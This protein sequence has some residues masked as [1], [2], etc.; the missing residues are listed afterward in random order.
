MLSQRIAL[1]V[2]VSSERQAEEHTIDSQ[3]A[4]LVARIAQDGRVLDPEGASSTRAT[5]APRWCAPRSSGCATWRLPARSIVFTS[6]RPTGSPAAT[7]TKSSCSMSSAAP[8]RGGVPQ[9][10]D[11]RLARGRPAIA[12]PGH[13]GRIRTGQAPQASRR[14]GVSVKFSPH[15]L[16]RYRCLPRMKPFLMCASLPHPLHRSPVAPSP[17][18][19]ISPRSEKIGYLCAVKPSSWKGSDRTA[20]AQL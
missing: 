19:V 17:S 8:A 15:A 7:P 14:G 12:G 16:Q 18:P 1:Y 4:A 13:G 11:R 10:A 5:A 9:P 6:I 2:R 3:V 20:E